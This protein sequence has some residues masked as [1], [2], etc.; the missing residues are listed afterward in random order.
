MGD[1]NSNTAKTIVSREGHGTPALVRLA[2]EKLGGHATTA[3]IIQWIET[4]K[5]EA[6]V[7]NVGVCLN[8][9]DTAA[10]DR[11][12]GTKVWHLTVCGCLSSR[13][14]FVKVDPNSRFGSWRLAA[15]EG[16][17]QENDVATKR[18]RVSS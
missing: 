15:N 8:S 6:V 11:P 4:N 16:D 13:S 3:Q 18:R 17:V 10:K 12:E 2:L 7:Q 5:N 1:A 14:E 9:K